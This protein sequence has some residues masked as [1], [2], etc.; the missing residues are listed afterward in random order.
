METQNL[1]AFLLVAET[2][3]FSQAAEKLHLTQPAVS[4][5]VAL[6]EEQLGAELFDRI[7]RVISLTEAGEA[8]LPH[9][10]A[11]Q[12]QLV[13]AE[14]S[15]R[16]LAV[17]VRE[18]AHELWYVRRAR[19]VSGVLRAAV[20]REVEAGLPFSGGQARAD[21][22][23]DVLNIGH[24]FAA[25]TAAF[26]CGDHIDNAAVFQRTHA[27]HKLASFKPVDDAHQTGGRDQ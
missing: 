7:G 4:K 6:L 23:I 18:S 10:K 14:Q 20:R 12:Q 8:L 16:D 19:E 9:A 11:V 17:M 26:F 2:G 5:R 24:D 25:K 3:S 13:Q 15:V 27:R 1:S 21:P 22:V